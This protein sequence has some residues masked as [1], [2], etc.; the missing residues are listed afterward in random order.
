MKKINQEESSKKNTIKPMS[1]IVLLATLKPKNELSHTAVLAKLLIEKL[2]R[3]D[4]QSEMIRLID[5][6]IRPGIKENMGKGDEWPNI[7]KKILA[8]DIIIFATPI[9]WGLHSSLMQ[10]VVERMD[11]LNDSLLETGT[12]P[13]ANKVASLVIT[14][15]EDGA[16]HITGNLLS[17]IT[18][19]GMTI[20]PGSSVSWLGDAEGKSEEQLTRLF[21]KEPTKLMIEVAG[22]NIVHMASFLGEKPYPIASQGIRGSIK[23]GTVGI[24]N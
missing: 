19:N 12:S 22:E 5:Y 3:S 21:S 1:A 7:L 2:G 14:G 9:W 16:Q 13:L 23:S 15:A 11:T 24:K 8:A 17:F 4:I 6:N 20:P 18:Y 10:R